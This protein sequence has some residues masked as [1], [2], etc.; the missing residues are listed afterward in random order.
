[1][2]E[3]EKSKLGYWYDANSDEELLDDRE[4]SLDLCIEFS[5]L[6]S[7][8][9]KRKIEIIKNLFGSVGKNLNIMSPFRCDYGYNIKFGDNVF[10]NYNCVIL[11]TADVIFGNDVFVGPNCS[12]VCA[13]HPLDFEDR[14]RGLEKALPIHIGNNVWIA[15]NVTVLPEPD[16]M[17]KKSHITVNNIFQVVTNKIT[18]TGALS[19]TLPILRDVF[20]YVRIA[21][22]LVFLTLSSLDY[23]KAIVDSDQSAFKKANKHLVKRLIILVAILI[24]PSIINLV[25]AI[26]QLSNGS[27]GIS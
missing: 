2:T 9:K 22:I 19:N 6:K 3:K 21:A 10:I 18:C 27:C 15:S 24:L 5:S 20:K 11:D 23:V 12:F 7:F 8:Q 16:K 25:L 26:V 14:N 17:T 4:R 1:M 13:V